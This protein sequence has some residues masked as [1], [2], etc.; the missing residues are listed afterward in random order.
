MVG[1]VLVQVRL[2][3][4]FVIIVALFAVAGTGR[5]V[6]AQE[7]FAV[8][9]EVVV[10]TYALNLRT[11]AGL[12]ADVV[13][14]LRDGTCAI[15][16]D[17]PVRAD[18]YTW[19]QLDV[20]GTVGW[21]AG[22]YLALEEGEHGFMPA[23]VVAVATTDAL[24]LRAAAGLDADVL[25]VLGNGDLATVLAGP[26]SAD[27]YDWY[28]LDIDGTTGWAVRDLLAFAPANPD[29]IALGDVVLVNTDTL[30]LRDEPTTAGAVLDVL[31]GGREGTVVGGPVAAD[32]YTWFE[33]ET[34]AGTGWVAGEYLLIA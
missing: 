29:M 14:V 8:N 24:N 4:S 31:T 11:D 17:G 7:G 19:Y 18:G 13:A 27:G 33:M 15:V 22:E 30:R 12:N 10:D 28:R 5:V 20:D 32:G 16:V 9:D 1:H 34:A 3:V 2:A 21:S 25:M 23:G 6:R 26:E